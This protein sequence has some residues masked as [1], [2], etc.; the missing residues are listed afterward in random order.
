MSRKIIFLVMIILLLCILSACGKRNKPKDPTS[1]DIYSSSG[2]MTSDVTE[3]DLAEVKEKLDTYAILLTDLEGRLKEVEKEL[4][5]VNA[6]LENISSSTYKPSYYEDNN[7][8]NLEYNSS[9]TTPIRDLKSSSGTFK[10][11]YKEILDRQYEQ[12]N[13]LIAIQQFDALRLS[14]PNCHLADNCLYW[15]GESLYQLEEYG[16]SINQFKELLR[17]Y[18]TTNKVPDAY[19]MMGLCYTRLDDYETAITYF[20]TVVNQ[21]DDSPLVARAK[22][23]VNR[24]SPLIGKH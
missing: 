12:G 6:K 14:E 22:K 20:R 3:E 11:R 8:S 23:Q 19:Y 9:S 1:D 13:Y 4:K 15:I 18:P 21:Y 16:E 24:L 5:K 2:T 17:V 10:K 7:P